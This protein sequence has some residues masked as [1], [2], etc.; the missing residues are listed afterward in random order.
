MVE[1]AHDADHARVRLPLLIIISDLMALI[2]TCD[3]CAG[4]E[5]T[6]S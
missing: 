5:G 6:R 1:G 3:M 4:S 2:H